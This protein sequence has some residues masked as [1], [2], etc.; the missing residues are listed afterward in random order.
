MCRSVWSMI[1]RLRQ[2]REPLAWWRH[3]LGPEFE[4]L[5]RLLTPCPGV[6]GKSYPCPDTGIRL[7]V[8]ESGAGYVAFATGDVAE[9]VPDLNLQWEDVQA[10]RLDRAALRRDLS[11]ALELTGCPADETGSDVE[12]AGFCDRHGQRKR[13]YLCHAHEGEAAARMAAD[14]VQ[15][16]EAGCLVFAERHAGADHVLRS[17][18][19]G[20]VALDECM[21]VGGDG[22]LGACGHVC[23]S[24]QPDMTHAELKEHLDR[25]LDNV[26]REFSDLQRENDSLKQDLA[27][28]LA[29]IARQVTPEFF[30][31]V[32]V[33]LG[34][35]SV[36]AAAQRL[37]IPGSTFADRVK[38][39]V[40]RGGVYKT[41]YSMLGVRRKGAGRKQIER[42]NE[43]FD[44][45]QGQQAVAEPGVLRELLDG[46]EDLN[47]ENWKS[48]RDELIEIARR[49]L[50]ER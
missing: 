26:G 29:S 39:Y 5:H 20:L 3:H 18:G 44:E 24:A 40:K 10:W 41:L 21:A 47:E 48:M 25:R 33:I 9:D 36:N 46:I 8:R 38:E 11:A 4:S 30:Q 43:L 27:Q 12:F 32:F 35:G 1:F 7:Q 50:P 37:G 13:V 42:F 14:A 34:T 17:R 28:V 49:E 16:V 19:I 2:A 22:F 23:R 45:H 15:T 6:A 31:W